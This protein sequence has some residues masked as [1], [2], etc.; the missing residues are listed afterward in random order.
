MASIKPPFTLE[1]ATQK[2]KFAQSMWNTQNPTQVSK[3]YTPDCT[4]R[5]RSSFIK[6]TDEI[7]AFLTKKWEKEKSYRLR[8]ELFCFQD[9][10]IAVQFWYE[11]QDAHD[12][13]KWKRCY[14]LEDWTFDENGK[15]RKRMMS[16]N[17][18]LLGKDGDG[19]A[20]PE[21]GIEG[22]WFVDSVDVEDA[23]I[24]EKHY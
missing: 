22:R 18:V 9:D 4:W 3:G 23:H 15:M 24:S 1:S 11:Y 7:I 21:E 16:G 10:K 20:V 19:V 17:D 5:N 14:G 6:G 12:G 8:K 2:L 13:M